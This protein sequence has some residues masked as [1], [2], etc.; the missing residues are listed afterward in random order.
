[1]GRYYRQTC[2]EEHY[3]IVGEPSGFY[4]SHV[5]PDNGSGIK[6]AKAIFAVMKDTP[7]EKK[8]KI[9]GS[10]S[11]AV[12]TGKNSGCI[13][14]LEALL[15]RP[16]QWAICLLHLNELPLRH[17]LFSTRW[18]NHWSKLIFRAHRKTFKWSCF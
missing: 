14:S 17:C 2:I 3:V 10:D 7:L 15:G 13:A 11:T 18:H 12:M 6:I 9:I 1:M 4:L 8:L 5:T 16:L